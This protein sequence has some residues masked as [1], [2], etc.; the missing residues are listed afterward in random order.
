MTPGET[1]RF[2]Q[3][4]VSRRRFLWMSALSAGAAAAGCATNPVTGKSQ[5]T[6]VSQSDEIRLDRQNSPHQFSADYGP[7]QD[8]GLNR[9]LDET[10][11]SLAALSHRPDMPYS[12]RAVNAVYINA[13]AFP[14]GSIAATRGILLSLEDEAEL[15]ALLGHELGHVNARHTAELMTRNMLTLAVVAGVAEYVRSE[16]EKYTGLTTGLGLLGSGLLLA[17]YSRDN[18]R[19]AD[20]LG[21]E[22][23]TRADYDPDGFTGLM[24]MLQ[25]LSK[26]K[27]N[28][29]ELMFSTHPMSE[30]RYRTAI[31]TIRSRYA[32]KHTNRFL[33][34]RYMDHT[35]NLRKLQPAIENMQKADAL[36][37]EQNYR[38]AETRLKSALSEA[39]GDY[40]ALMMMAKCQ[41]ALDQ[42][43]E[44]LRYTQAAR[45][46]YP[47]E[48][49]SYQVEGVARLH[50]N[51]Y[52]PA[53]KNFRE[54]EKRLPD[55][56][57]TL[58]LKGLAL[59]NLKRTGEAAR[60][61]S[62][63]LESVSEGKQAEYATNRL[64]EWGYISAPQS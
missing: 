53:L 60:E 43:G 40:T 57:N 38:E 54:Y 24:D 35:V 13:Y 49:Q 44:A 32:G 26:R 7:A 34:E 28:A 15:A 36:M 46:A 10:G 48:A 2:T 22:Y 52:E 17:H 18:E 55:N 29:I 1:D 8:T 27:P 6:L 59:E 50:L 23:M 14:G 31:E 3:I 62:R 19:Q 33:K 58:F 9:Y 63:Y 56:P 25:N 37:G 41:Y 20:A 12:F 16:N 47:E 21:L 5:F 51:Q 42:H 45:E 39:P 4:P 30:Q 11:R 61:Y 64:V